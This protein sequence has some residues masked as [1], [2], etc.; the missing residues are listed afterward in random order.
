MSWDSYIQDQLLA[1][2]CIKHAIICGHDGNIWA[3]SNEINVD[4][5][6]VK[7]FIT[8]FNQPGQEPFKI[9]GLRIA[10]EK[11]MYLS[12][13][14]KVARFK[15]G[16]S[17]IHTIKTTQAFIICWYAEP[18]MPEQAASVTEKLGDYLIQVGY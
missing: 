8:N 4:P 17:G 16:T 11:F 12:S 6:E 7:S 9:S 10:G 1:T 15:K 18:T 5:A 3:K 2:K 13:N 14:E